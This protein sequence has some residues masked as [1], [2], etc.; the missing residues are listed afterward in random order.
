MR[1]ICIIMVLM[2][3]LAS[4]CA[5]EENTS[6]I[7]RSLLF[8]NPDRITTRISPDGSMMSFLAPVDGV[9]NV[10]IGPAA[11]PDKAKPVTND[12][13]R[14]IQSYF[15]AYTNQHILYLQDKNGDENWRIYSVN[16]SSG[17]IKDLTPF[18]GVQSQ[19]QAISYKFPFECIIGLNRRDPRWHDLFRLNIET[20]NLT[21]IQEN[22]RFSDF[23]VDDDFKIRLADN[24]TPE[25]GTEIFKLMD[26]GTWTSFMKVD[27]EDTLTTRFGGFNKTNERIYFVDSRDRNTA[28]LYILDLDTGEKSLVAQDPTSDYGGAMYHPT[29][30]IVQ[31]AAFYYD[32]LK[33]EIIDPDISEDMEY[34]A[35][36]DFGEVRVVSRSLDDSVWIVVYTVDDSPARYYHYD[37]S[38][39]RAE[40]LFTDRQELENKSLS[41]MYPAVIRSR[42]GLDLLSYYTLPLGSDAN[43]DGLPD[44]P[45]PMVLDVHGGPWSRVYWGLD[46]IHQWLANRGYAVLSVNFRGS[47]GLGKNF[48]NAGNLE[49]GGKMQDDL[50]DAVNWSIETGI[51]DP[52]KVAIFGG[53]YGGYAALA[54]L[55]F[56]PEVFACGVDICGISNL[57]TD[58]K[59]VPPYWLPEIEMD[60][61]RI[62]DYRTKEGEAFLMSRSPIS[63]VDRIQ[64]PLLIA[65]GANDPRVKQNESEQIVNAMNEKGLPVTYVL[66]ADE[67]HGFA[68]PENRLSFYA[69]AEAFLAEC[70]GGRY[71]PIGRDFEGANFTVPAGV[72]GI[73]GLAEALGGSA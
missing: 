34:L 7:S 60:F 57:V 67:G 36:L 19:I 23:E 71:E 46:S 2:I 70:L 27:M 49:W 54:G 9:L 65:H 4:E 68:R 40:F 47:T 30:K 1:Q 3:M 8:G 29:K 15:W 61:K 33:W 31:A 43:E 41:R 35:G 56:T 59:S 5:A 58:L 51:A 39:R 45:L 32:T 13:Y 17:K 53:S 73:P 48:T 42:D 37:H 22:S 64:R 44:K 24:T 6:L 11:Q 10:W 50:I 52:K 55:T 26:N 62:G 16:L 38:K 69:I 12:T 21:L 28:A 18:E 25:G 63:Y 20:G 72:D 66:Y 14:G